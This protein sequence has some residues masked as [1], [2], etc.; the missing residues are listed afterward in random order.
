LSDGERDIRKL[1]IAQ[2]TSLLGLQMMG[3]LSLT[4]PLFR[5][6][7]MSDSKEITPCKNYHLSKVKGGLTSMCSPCFVSKP[8]SEKKETQQSTTDLWKVRVQRRG[9]VHA[10]DDL[11][12]ALALSSDGEVPF[13]AV[14]QDCSLRGMQDSHSSYSRKRCKHVLQN[15]ALLS[16]CHSPFFWLSWANDHACHHC[17][18]YT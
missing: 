8:P 12:P 17:E 3:L 18:V 11:V 15:L 14:L 1:Y 10:H 5:P 7:S 16:L 4:I 9:C 2:L 6:S 13:D